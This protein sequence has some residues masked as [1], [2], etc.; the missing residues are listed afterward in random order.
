MAVPNFLVSFSRDLVAPET[1]G[2]SDAC[3]IENSE[4]VKL[5]SFSTNIHRVE[6]A[7][8]YKADL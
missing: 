4:E 6:A 1:F 8:S 3:I 2:E 7:V 5:R